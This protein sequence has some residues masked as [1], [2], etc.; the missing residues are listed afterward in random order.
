MAVDR[1]LGAAVDV[2]F[3]LSELTAEKTLPDSARAPIEELVRREQRVVHRLAP[4]ATYHPPQRHVREAAADLEG[5]THRTS[6]SIPW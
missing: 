5:L 6:S 4:Y 3:R 1:D 2:M